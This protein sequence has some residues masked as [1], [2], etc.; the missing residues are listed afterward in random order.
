KPAAIREYLHSQRL[1]MSARSDRSAPV[2]HPSCS[3]V[4]ADW[5]T[6]APKYLASDRARRRVATIPS[7][8]GFPPAF[9]S[10][11]DGSTAAANNKCACKAEFL[12]CQSWEQCDPC[13]SA[14]I[15]LV[16]LLLAG[17][18]DFLVFNH[19]LALFDQILFI[20]H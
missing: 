1:Q 12:H 15:H 5:H 2:P 18:G 8:C 14:L 11:W 10:E 19:V 13:R 3:L 6:P 4:A 17:A 9:R 20:D 16:H 7:P